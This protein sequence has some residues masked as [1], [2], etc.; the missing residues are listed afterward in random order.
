MNRTL[1]SPIKKFAPPAWALLYP[2]VRNQ[3]AS[4]ADSIVFSGIEV[5][6]SGKFWL[7]TPRNVQCA[8]QRLPDHDRI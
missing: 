6:D 3:F 8:R 1:P 7:Y 5:P 2:Q 4:T